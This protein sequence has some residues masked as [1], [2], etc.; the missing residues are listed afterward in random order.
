MSEVDHE[1]RNVA[2]FLSAWK[3]TILYTFSHVTV[4]NMPLK[5]VF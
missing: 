1:C 2:S 4:A 3:Q 5:N